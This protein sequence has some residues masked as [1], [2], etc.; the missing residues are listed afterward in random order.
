MRLSETDIARVEILL[1]ATLREEAVAETERLQ[2]SARSESDRLEVAGLFSA[3]GR[4]D[5]AQRLMMDRYV[6][7]LA[8]GP[9]KG[10]EELWSY[11]W[12]RAFADRVESATAGD[13]SLEAGL[14]YSVMREE[15]GF[16]PEVVSP[17]GARGL[18]QIM[19]ETGARLARELG[20][21]FDEQVLFDPAT[22]VRFGSHYLSSL[23][24]RFAGRKAPAV[25]SYNAGPRAVERWLAREAKLEE[26]EW[27]E[28]IPYDETR[29]YVR[30]VLRSLHV[31]RTL[32]P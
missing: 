28:A 27:V 13:P 32:Y 14:V 17:V 31:Y 29:G 7:E 10:R 5:R 20:E 25:A 8:Q 23:L 2:R 19:P 26:D 15:S 9:R 3:A 11:A 30:R 12:P 6:E 1:E 4:F 18:L 22:N 16:R 24:D 21:P